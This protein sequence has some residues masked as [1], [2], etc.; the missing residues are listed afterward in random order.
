LSRLNEQI[1][2]D[3]WKKIYLLRH[4]GTLPHLEGE[5]VHYLVKEDFKTK[6]FDQEVKESKKARLHYKALE[7][8]CVEVQLFTGRYHQIR[9]QFAHIGAPI[10]GDT[11][12]GAREKGIS[13]G[14]DLHH[15]RV[16]FFH[17]VTKE[18]I[19]IFSSPPF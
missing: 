18:H 3:R 5:L 1:K 14:I 13:S 10:C 7:K 6:V 17:P 4:E 2:N 9:A 11:K 8:N 15:T 19:S 12:Y 16:E